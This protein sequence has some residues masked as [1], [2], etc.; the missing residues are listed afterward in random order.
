[1]HILDLTLAVRARPTHNVPLGSGMSFP[2]LL[3]GL[4]SNVRYHAA[5]GLRI[6]GS[7]FTTGKPWPDAGEP[8]VS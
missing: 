6:V 3:P 1:M 8:A 2:G 5:A 7:S 4:G